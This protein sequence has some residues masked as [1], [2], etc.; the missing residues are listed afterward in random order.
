MKLF[1][2]LMLFPVLAFSETCFVAD[3]PVPNKI[4][5]QICI[6]SAEEQVR[7]EITLVLAADTSVPLDFI[8]ADRQVQTEEKYK[9]VAHSKTTNE[10]EQMCGYELTYK[11]T[12]KG[13]SAFSV[14]DLDNLEISA[15]IFETNDNCHSNG[16]TF[17]V[18]YKK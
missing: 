16:K 14:I 1:S 17:T 6:S 5:T 18:N 9:F 12:I 3:R 11:Y 2:L 15:K 8:I 13:S 7:D 10:L 4:A